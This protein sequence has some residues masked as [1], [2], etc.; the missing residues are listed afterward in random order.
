MSHPH[1][2]NGNE[3]RHPAPAWRLLFGT[4]MKLI[5]MAIAALSLVP[6]EGAAQEL[7]PHVVYDNGTADPDLL[8]Q[9]RVLVTVIG[10]TVRYCGPTAG[11]L[12]Q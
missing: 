7:C 11:T 5:A 10:G 9:I 2:R 12:C 6:R 8:H 3:S 4:A 1:S